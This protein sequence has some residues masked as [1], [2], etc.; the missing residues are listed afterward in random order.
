MLNKGIKEKSPETSKSK[1]NGAD[2]KQ[3]SNRLSN[4]RDSME[5]D[6]NKN[7]GEMN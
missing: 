6:I 3:L 1:T 4:N 5:E 2:S 7:S